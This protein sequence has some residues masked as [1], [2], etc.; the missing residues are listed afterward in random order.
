MELNPLGRPQRDEYL[1]L[2]L[3]DAAHGLQVKLDNSRVLDSITR[4]PLFLAEVVDLYRSGK[5]IPTTKMGVLGAVMD[6]IEQ[7]PEHRTS[8]QQAPLRGHAAGYLRALSM[9][10]DRAR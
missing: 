9:E 10:N 8:L 7:S 3:G 6:A 5:D 2:A 1:R 4:T